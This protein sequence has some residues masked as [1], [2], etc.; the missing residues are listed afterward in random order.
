MRSG[1][2]T[3][4]FASEQAYNFISSYVNEFAGLQVNKL[5]VVINTAYSSNHNYAL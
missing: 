5:F 3:E 2:F 4:F 1:E